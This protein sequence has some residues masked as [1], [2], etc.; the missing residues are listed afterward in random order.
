MKVQME[1][2]EVVSVSK[3]ENQMEMKGM[4]EVFFFVE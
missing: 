3:R 1:V 4:V 2:G